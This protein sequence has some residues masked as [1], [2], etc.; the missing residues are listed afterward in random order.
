MKGD[1][2]NLRLDG[3]WD[4]AL[5]FMLQHELLRDDA[6]S[7]ASCI[8]KHIAEPVLSVR[9]HTH[10]GAATPAAALARAIDEAMSNVNS[11]I[12]SVAMLEF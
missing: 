2:L 6:V 7:F 5:G 10:A 1:E 12:A 11:I 4:H 3:Q 9:V 8:R